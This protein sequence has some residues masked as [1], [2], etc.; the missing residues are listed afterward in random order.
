MTLELSDW[1]RIIHPVIAVIFVFP[2]IGISLYFGLQNR[3]RRQLIASGEKS[4]IPAIVGLEHVKV[5]KWL[6]TAV[7]LLTLGGMIHPTIKKM[8]GSNLWNTE[9]LRVGLVVLVLG[10]TISALVMLYRATAEQKLWR[11]IWS[12]LAIS[13]TIAIGFQGGMHPFGIKEFNLP[14]WGIPGAIYR[15]DEEWFFSHFYFGMIVTALMVVS[16]AIIPEIYKDRSQKW[17][18][19]HVILNCFALLLFILQGVTG[20]RDLLEIPLEWQAPAIYRC[21]FVQKNCNSLLK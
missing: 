21:D 12:V 1:L 8:V 4:A 16:L 6:T 20:V 14:A 7:L 19:T 2:L 3:Q 5:G 13:G 10:I 11:I 15:R 18:N 9:P 17:R